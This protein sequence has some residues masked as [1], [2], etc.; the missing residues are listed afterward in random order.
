MLT[1]RT[2]PGLE[3]GAEP[4]LKHDSSINALIRHYRQLKGQGAE[5]ASE[6]T[7]RALPASIANAE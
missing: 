7:K 5:K 6:N 4:Q 1:Q 3:S 2:I